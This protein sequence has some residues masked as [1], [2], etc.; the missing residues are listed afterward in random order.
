MSRRGERAFFAPWVRGPYHGSCLLRL[1]LRK[2]IKARQDKTRLAN[3]NIMALVSCACASEGQGRQDRTRQDWPTSKCQEE[4][5]TSL[6]QTGESFLFGFDLGANIHH[7]SSSIQHPACLVLVMV[8]V[9][10]LVFVLVLGPVLVLSW[11][12]W[13]CLVLKLVLS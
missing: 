11:S 1:F 7:P 13:S 5:F 10:D 2:P 8:M 12:W 4:S 6:N 9:L 3:M